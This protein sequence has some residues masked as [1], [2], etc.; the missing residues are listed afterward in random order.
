MGRVNELVRNL[1]SRFG[2]T[3]ASLSVEVVLLKNTPGV[4]DTIDSDPCRLFYD[5]DAYTPDLGWE[6]GWIYLMANFPPPENSFYLTYSEIMSLLRK[7]PHYHNFEDRFGGNHRDMGIQFSS[8]NHQKSE[9]I[10]N[11]THWLKMLCALYD[12]KQGKDANLSLVI[13]R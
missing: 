2:V 1:E 10:I 13:G 3:Y 4:P 6:G 8:L 11:S 5:E 7:R 9:E 12:L